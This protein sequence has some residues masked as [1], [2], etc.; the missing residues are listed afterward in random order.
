MN[1]ICITC[2]GG[3]TAQYVIILLANAV[4]L[5]FRRI[6][7]GLVRL[8]LVGIPS[9]HIYRHDLLETCKSLLRLFNAMCVARYDDVVSI[10]GNK[11]SRLRLRL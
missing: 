3:N 9:Q 5:Y 1:E 11:D 6:A 8:H 2:T 10:V 7:H 4:I